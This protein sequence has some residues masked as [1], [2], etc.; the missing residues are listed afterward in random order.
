MDKFNQIDITHCMDSL[1]GLKQ[2]PSDFVDCCVTSP[3]YYGL[4]DYGVDGQIGLEKSPMD[5]INRLTEVFMEVFRVL[6]P[7]GTLW[8]VIGDSYAGGNKGAARYPDNA[9]KWKQGTNKGTVGNRTAYKYVTDC[10]DSQ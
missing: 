7:D 5:Y 3:P 6:K 2:M 8:L 10:K 1:E 9:K 4:R